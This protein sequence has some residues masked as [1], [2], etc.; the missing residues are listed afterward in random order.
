MSGAECAS[1]I[2]D[3][4][5]LRSELK[6]ASDGIYAPLMVAVTSSISEEDCEMCFEKGFDAVQSKPVSPQQMR[7]LLLDCVA[8]VYSM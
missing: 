4:F 8:Y 6:A 1:Q 2:R 3:H 7:F 5:L